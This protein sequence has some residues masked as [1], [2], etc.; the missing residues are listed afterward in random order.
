LGEK[1]PRKLVATPKLPSI[2]DVMCKKIMD[3]GMEKP[4]SILLDTHASDFKAAKNL[5][6]KKHKKALELNE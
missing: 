2:A 6:K 3:C 1:A 5:I 4:V